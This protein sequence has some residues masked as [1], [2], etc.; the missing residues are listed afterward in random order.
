M[1]AQI[2]VPT[3][4]LGGSLWEPQVAL[5]AMAVPTVPPIPTANTR[6]GKETSRDPLGDGKWIDLKVP[7]D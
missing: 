1:A 5:P 2:A 4:P 7:L 6:L 3:F